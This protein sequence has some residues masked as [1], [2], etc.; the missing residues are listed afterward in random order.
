[1]VMKLVA[2]KSGIGL[3]KVKWWPQIL[4]SLR[5][6]VREANISMHPTQ[7]GEDG[8]VEKSMHFLCNL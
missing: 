5:L 3:R 2:E 1:M 4:P 7:L 6:W 8:K